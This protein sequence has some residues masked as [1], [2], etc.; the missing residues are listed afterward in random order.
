MRAAVRALRHRNF[1]LWSAGAL[2]SNIGT[3]MQRIAQDWLV[4]TML[5]HHSAAALGLVTALQFAP[6]L[7]LLPWI[8]SAADRFDRRHLL[9]LTQAAMGLLSFVFGLLI[10]SGAV[11]LWQAYGFAFLSGCAAAFDAPARQS[12]V[13]E[14]VGGADLPNAVALNAMSFNAGR[15]L[16]PAVAG[17]VIARF[18]AGLAFLIN[19]LSF[20]AVILALLRL[21][22]SA[23]RAAP[24]AARGRG[25]FLEGLR[26]AWA[27]PRLRGCLIMLALIGT[28]GLNFPIFVATMA[29]RVL[30][31]GPAGY[32]LLNALMALGTIA[33]AFFAATRPK[34]SL[35]LLVLAAALFGLGFL[36]AALIPRFSVFAVCLALIGCAALIFTT[37]TNSLMQLEAA[38]DMRGRM[39]ALRVAV[40]LGGAPL[41]APLTGWIADAA[42]PRA[43]LLV[44]AAAGLAAASAGLWL[45]H[46]KNRAI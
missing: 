38:P 24:R 25:G 18:G 22:R 19:G 1:R 17:F 35:R 36:P 42:G 3:W 37:G 14:L 32:G 28:F 33:G 12:F 7:L 21:R 9:I 40:A 5:T 34:P 26:Y 39:M 27:A 31:Q 11:R 16:G 15:M 23:L 45:M 41:G 43:A 20:L 6:Q 13:S 10:L 29:T 8:G 30:H 44:G 2:V 46:K 4:L